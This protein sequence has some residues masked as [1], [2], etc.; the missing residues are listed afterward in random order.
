L[1]YYRL[2][3][4]FYRRWAGLI[5]I[6]AL[7]GFALG[8][9]LYFGSIAPTYSILDAERSRITAEASALIDELKGAEVSSDRRLGVLSD[10]VALNEQRIA[11]ETELARLDATRLPLILLGGVLTIAFGAVALGVAYW[12]EYRDVTFR[13]VRQ[14]ESALEIGVLCALPT[15]RGTP[16]AELYSELAQKLN[17]IEGGKLT[18]IVTSADADE[19]KSLTLHHLAPAFAENG[20]RTLVID[21]DLRTP[22]QHK[23]FKLSNRE[24]L[25]NLVYAYSP[26]APE[27][28]AAL[29]DA[30]IKPVSDTISVLT[31]GPLPANPHDLI[32]LAKFPDALQSLRRAFDVILI[33]T[34]AILATPDALPLLREADG[35]LFIV[36]SR[37]TRRRQAE[38]ALRLIRQSGGRVFGVVLNRAKAA[39]S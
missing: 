30:Y 9:L 27:M 28:I 10:Y 32:G 19:G 18:L 34:P 4:P 23:L 14:I 36:D 20:R 38:A 15:I 3:R 21:A 16:P 8:L 24:G 22:A 11:L 33:D 31:T 1:L 37:R 5:L 6:G 35:V 26:A 12:L 7:L 13:S 39:M 17:A 29:V 25:A 2:T